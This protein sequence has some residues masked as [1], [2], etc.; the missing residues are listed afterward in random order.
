MI[1]TTLVFR[2]FLLL[3]HLHVELGDATLGG[4]LPHYG[5]CRADRI[6]LLGLRR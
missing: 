4:V 1:A 5:T 3:R 6:G 2:Q